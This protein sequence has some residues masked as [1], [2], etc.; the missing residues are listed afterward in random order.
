VDQAHA[1]ALHGL[2]FEEVALPDLPTAVRAG[3]GRGET[4]ILRVRTDS[5]ASHARRDAVA[6]A[7][8]RSVRTSLE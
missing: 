7:V 2:P 8:V 1:A 5:E 6:R 3:L 4:R